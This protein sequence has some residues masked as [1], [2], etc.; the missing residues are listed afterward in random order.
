VRVPML[1]NEVIDYSTSLNYTDCIKQCQGKYNL[2]ELLISKSNK[3]LVL[4][5]KKGFVIPIGKWLKNELRRDLEDK[6]MNMPDELMPLFNRKM[7]A[8]MFSEHVSGKN[9]WGWMLW[10]LYSLVNWHSEHRNAA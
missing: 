5:P 2:K 4:Q 8:E 6:V 10:A 9:D 1:S 3:E 7:L